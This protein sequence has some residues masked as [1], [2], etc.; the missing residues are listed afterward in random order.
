[1]KIFRGEAKR[2]MRRF[3]GIKQENF[4][5]FLKECQWRMNG[6]KDRQLKYWYKQ[7]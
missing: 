4:Y 2:H 3:K 7:P 6:G 1:M 5:W